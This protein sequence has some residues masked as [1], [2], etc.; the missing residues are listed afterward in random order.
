MALDLQF[1]LIFDYVV[2]YSYHVYIKVTLC[3]K[4]LSSGKKPL[5]EIRQFGVEGFL[6]KITITKNCVIS[7]IR[8]IS[9][10]S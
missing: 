2:Q 9:V 6:G 5:R 7:V 10:L 3:R 1:H 4:E 8:V